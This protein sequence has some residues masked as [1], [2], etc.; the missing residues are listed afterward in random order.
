MKEKPDVDNLTKELYTN[1][2]GDIFNFLAVFID[3][4]K[5]RK[6]GQLAEGIISITQELMVYY[7]KR[8]FATVTL[9]V[10]IMLCIPLGWR[11]NH[12]YVDCIFKQL[13]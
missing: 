11:L 3:Q 10:K 8:I 13:L 7:A 4:V 1:A 6:S 9:Q 5:K 2:A 12:R